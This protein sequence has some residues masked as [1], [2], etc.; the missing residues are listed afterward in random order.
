MS[1]ARPAEHLLKLRIICVQPP[2]PAA[3]G[4]VF[5][6]QEN[7]K[8]KAWVIHPGQVQ[9]NGDIHFECECRVRLEPKAPRFLGE[10]VNGPPD[11][12]FIYLSWR[13]M[14][15]T[16]GATE[17]ACPAWVRRI[18]VHFKTITATQIEAALQSKGV[19]EASIQGTG[20]DGGP[21]CASVPLMGGGWKL[22]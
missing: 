8:T 5:G 20:R 9:P 12:R 4:A 18:K 1:A 13:P 11:Q 21:S 2:N 14:A 6:L 15:W 10:F 19:L 16:P 7:S 3:H 17:P 22:R